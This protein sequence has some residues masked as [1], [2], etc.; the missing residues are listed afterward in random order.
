MS[1]Y[2]GTVRPTNRAVAG[3]QGPPEV[4]FISIFYFFE[5]FFLKYFFCTALGDSMKLPREIGRKS[6]VLST[7][8]PSGCELNFLK[9]L[10]NFQGVSNFCFTKNRNS[11]QN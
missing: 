4:C 6:D 10:F 7:F 3:E 9:R 5:I 2:R 8:F 11:G 1:N